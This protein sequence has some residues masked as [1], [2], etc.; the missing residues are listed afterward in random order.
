MTTNPYKHGKHY[1]DIASAAGWHWIYRYLKYAYGSVCLASFISSASRSA[2]INFKE[3]QVSLQSE[4][5]A[6]C[7][8]NIELW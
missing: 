1:S 2:F 8:D 6:L 5:E 7:W 4:S 3:Q